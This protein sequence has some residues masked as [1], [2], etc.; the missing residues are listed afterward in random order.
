MNVNGI[1]NINNSSAIHGFYNSIYQ[2]NMSLN[3]AKLSKYVFPNNKAQGTQQLG[4]E[5]LQYV[6]NIKSASKDLSS[7]LKELSGKAFTNKTATSSDT[8]AMSVKYTG[9]R[10]NDIKQTTVKIDQTAAGQVNEGAKLNAKESFGASG[11]NKFSIDINGKTTEFSIDVS[12]S[13]SNSDVQQKMAD[14]INKAGIGVNATVEKSTDG[15]SSLL[16]LEATSTGD[17]DKSKFTVSDVSGNL[18][19][20]TGANEISSEARNA[21]YSVNGGAKQTSQTNNVDLGGG[22]NVTFNKASDKDVTIS[23]SKDTEY[24]KSE[25]GDMVKSYNNLFSQ[26]AQMT[27][28][29][30][31]QNLASKMINVSKTYSG[32]LS[33]IGIGFDRDGQMTIDSKKLNEAAENGKLEKFFTENSGKNYGF[34]NQLSRLADNVSNN[35][36]NF[37]S[38]NELGNSLTENFAYNSFGGMMQY[39]A[40]S[41]GLLFDY[42]Y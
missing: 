7:S 25:V 42:S 36:S 10:P 21:V 22:L 40:S 26:A 16:K 13:D 39:N 11:T 19:A 18:A 29:P 31:A 27:N 12:A 3:N 6:K 15:N 37:V 38:K 28:D 41:I 34:T 5:A 4:G 9:N 33:S 32:S 1:N 20:K 35:T 24:A 8:E 17:N 30:K 2:G 14:A 23:A